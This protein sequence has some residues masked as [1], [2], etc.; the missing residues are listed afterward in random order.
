MKGDTNQGPEHS[1]P[2][3]FYAEGTAQLARTSL[4]TPGAHMS[5][6]GNETLTQSPDEATRNFCT[7]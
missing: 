6:C 2:N 5:F 4:G 7:R 1:V 3:L